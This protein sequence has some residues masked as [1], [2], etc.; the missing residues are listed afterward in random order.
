MR[1]HLSATLVLLALAATAGRCRAGTTLF[2]EGL[3]VNG[4]ATALP[5]PEG[6]ER[7]EDGS[8]RLGAA[9]IAID[10]FAPATAVTV[11]LLAEVPDEGT[12]AFV[13]MSGLNGSDVYTFQCERLSQ[14]AYALRYNGD[15]E[16]KTARTPGSVTPGLH[17]FTFIHVTTAGTTLYCDGEVVAEATGIR[18]SSGTIRSVTLG[19]TPKGQFPFDGLRILAA[20][21]DTTAATPPPD[22]PLSVFLEIPEALKTAPAEILLH[23]LSIE[24]NSP[25]RLE[26]PAVTR[27]GTALDASEAALMLW[28]FGRRTAF[29]LAL[30]VQ[31]LDCDP[32]TG[33]SLTLARDSAQQNG[34][35]TLL[36]SPAPGE[37]WT[38]LASEPAPLPGGTVAVDA[39]RLAGCAFFKFRPE[40]QARIVGLTPHWAGVSTLAN[41]G[42]PAKGLSAELLAFS[43]ADGLWEDLAEMPL[44]LT[45]SGNACTTDATFTLTA[46]GT[47]LYATPVREPGDPARWRVA[48]PSLP[49]R[50]VVAKVLLAAE[51]LAPGSL[52]VESCSWDDALAGT[53]LR[54][55]AVLADHPIADGFV[56][57][58]TAIDSAA[59]FY[60][61]PAL[62]TDG[63]GTLVAVY[64]VRYGGGDLGDSKLSGIDLG[65]NVSTDG[66]TTWNAPHLALD[67]PNFRLPDGSWPYGT[68]RSAITP[69][70]DAGD[71]SILYD[72]GRDRFWLMTIT[73]G[74]LSTTGTNAAQNDCVLYTRENAPDALW[75]PWDGG[76]E[77]N[78]RSVKAILLEAIGKR[79]APGRGILQGPGHGFAT[80]QAHEG[81]P[82]GTLVFP[83]QAFVNS[84]L[85][86]AQ[87]FAAYSPDGGA[88]WKATAL[89]PTPLAQSPHNA[90]ENCI[91]ELD[92]GSWLMMSKGGSASAGRRLFFR[93]TDF[94]TWRQLASVSGIA[95]VQGSC[96][97]LGR[98]A[99]GSGR[100]VFAHQNAKTRANLTLYFGRD[101]TA[102]N[103]EAGQEGVA[104]DLGSLALHQGDT[105]GMGYNS[106]CLVDAKTLGV[107]YEAN[108]QILFERVDLTP[109]LK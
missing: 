89:T 6:A 9:P 75:L 73:G 50:D 38:I 3:V 67:V 47:R 55:A 46:G 60:R 37:P 69:A 28:L 92:D 44:V 104:W 8:V 85:N 26:V 105:G 56:P 83:M 16:H 41:D 68:S 86:D 10:G 93:S 61:I 78:T 57:D 109:Y 5:L 39:E 49:S 22:P 81:M 14:T 15:K 2:P 17:L 35:L 80:T 42:N 1:R 48:F 79:D 102:E 100:Y 21:I 82:A 25:E 30:D 65:E 64:D 36:G 72:P 95:Y 13:G 27:K 103:P 4:A 43:V 11:S 71:A 90:Q 32:E 45:L 96:L 101:I 54:F 7:L 70:M 74:G 53:T 33:L 29:D 108:G 62:A 94:T 99:D 51:S 40:A 58:D 34:W 84:S 66:G 24:G 52:T 63:A 91:L 59:L 76:P 107:L 23:L 19:A 31:D 106:L 87:A 18:W 20:D 77:G 97:R 12:G 88:T 98:G